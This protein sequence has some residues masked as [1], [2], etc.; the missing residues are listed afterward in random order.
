[1]MVHKLHTH[2]H[3]RARTHLILALRHAYLCYW[4][5]QPEQSVS[6]SPEAQGSYRL[7]LRCVCASATPL[8]VSVCV[9]GPHRWKWQHQE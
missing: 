9:A 1:M 7:E 5:G 6:R 8:C 2:T 4:Q 3:P